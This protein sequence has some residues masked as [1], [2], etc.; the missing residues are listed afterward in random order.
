MSTHRHPS[1]VPI[2]PAD[3]RPSGEPPYW[4]P[5]TVI[6]WRYGR[7]VRPM[8]VVR[9]DAVGLVAWLAPR[10]PVLK[11]VLANGN[12][13]RSVPIGPARFTTPRASK[14]DVW[15]GTGILKIAPTGVPWSVWVFWDDEGGHREWYVN[16]EQIHVRDKENVYTRDHV[17]DLVVH[18]DRRVVRKDE[19]E[20]AA[21][22]EV[23]RFDAEV[24]AQIEE[25]ADEVERS[26][27]AWEPPFC[28]GWERWRPD[29]DW[30]LPSLPPTFTPHLP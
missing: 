14:R 18:P 30:P 17:L 19:D 4:E 26:V 2:P 10:T 23:G 3:L 5:G 1:D 24:A 21:A 6:C 11:S 9:D 29:P 16:L 12:D 27:A 28:D 8:R 25:A 22:V 7:A 13:I 20:F 15:H